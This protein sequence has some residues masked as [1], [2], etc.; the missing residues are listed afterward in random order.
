MYR[1][2]KV[3]DVADPYKFY[4]PAQGVLKSMKHRMLARFKGV[5]HT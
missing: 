3:K 5:N 2:T 1:V 4:H